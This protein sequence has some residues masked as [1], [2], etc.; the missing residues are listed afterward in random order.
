MRR[1]SVCLPCDPKTLGALFV[2]L[3]FVTHLL[4]HSHDISTYHP[5]SIKTFTMISATDSRHERIWHA[6]NDLHEQEKISECIKQGGSN[7]F[8]PRMP[9]YWRVRTLCTLVVVEDIESGWARADV[10]DTIASEVMVIL[11][12]ISAVARSR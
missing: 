4:D 6:L 8:D 11:T 12:E 3:N 9:L 1:Q 7:L 5:P 10:S 2:N